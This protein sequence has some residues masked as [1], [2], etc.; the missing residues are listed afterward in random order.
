MPSHLVL[1]LVLNCQILSRKKLSHYYFN[2]WPYSDIRDRNHHWWKSNFTPWISCIFWYFLRD[3]FCSPFRFWPAY[4][5]LRNLL[6]VKDAFTKLIVIVDGEEA[7]FASIYAVFVNTRADPTLLTCKIKKKLMKTVICMIKQK[8]HW[9]HTNCWSEESSVEHLEP[10]P[11]LM[12]DFSVWRIRV[13]S[14]VS[15]KKI[16][17]PVGKL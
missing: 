3:G 14:S 9:T 13:L 16:V 6:W 17:S 12:V 5:D 11:S 10:L 15:K 1:A 2:K 7:A 8:P 4:E